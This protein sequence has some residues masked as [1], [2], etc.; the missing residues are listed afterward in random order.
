MRNNA[1]MATETPAPVQ[2]M[3]DAINAGDTEAFVAAFTDD[4]YVDDWGRVLRGPEGIRS[5]AATDAIGQGAQMRIVDATV[6]GDTVTTT[7]AWTSRRFNGESTG[8]FVIDE[9]LV[10]SFAIPPH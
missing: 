7:F 2:R 5:W 9:G 4:G 8:I 6:D 10:A 3:V 1:P